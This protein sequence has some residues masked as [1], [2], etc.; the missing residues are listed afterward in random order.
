MHRQIDIWAQMNHEGKFEHVSDLS[1]PE[2]E[3]RTGPVTIHA[4]RL[5]QFG[6]CPIPSPA[7]TLDMIGSGCAIGDIVQLETRV[8]ER[9]ELRLVFAIHCA[10]D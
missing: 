4:L 3:P 9:V 8:G 7:E 2:F 5:G 6:L 10:D 1:S